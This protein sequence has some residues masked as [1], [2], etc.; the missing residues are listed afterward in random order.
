MVVGLKTYYTLDSNIYNFLHK[1]LSGIAFF[2]KEND[3]FYIKS[4]KNKLIEEFLTKKVIFI[5]NQ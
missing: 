2:R 4:P 5:V 1:N 3:K